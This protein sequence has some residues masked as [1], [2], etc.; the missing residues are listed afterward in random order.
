MC[1]PGRVT[2][3][4]DPAPLASERALKDRAACNR[5]YCIP[6]TM[7][8]V[9]TNSGG[10]GSG[11]DGSGN[12]GSG[13]DGSGNDG[14]GDDGSGDDSSAGL[15]PLAKRNVGKP[16]PTV[17][18]GKTHPRCVVTLRDLLNTVDRSPSPRGRQA[19]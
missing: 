2:C 16:I 8:A 15:R 18:V 6:L 5:V 10:G 12:D 7:Q 19:S 3:Q 17:G 14:S 11:N 9:T 1:R 13:D 4:A